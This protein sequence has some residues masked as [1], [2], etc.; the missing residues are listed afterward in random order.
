[1]VSFFIPSLNFVLLLFIILL[2]NSS[3]FDFEWK[4][5][6]VLF[7]KKGVLL[8]KNFG[9]LFLCSLLIWNSFSLLGIMI[10][11][12]SG[13]IYELEITLGQDSWEKHKKGQQQQSI[14]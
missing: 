14:W 1:M 7:L 4:I 8:L 12:E 6:F 2:F 9:F 10:L 11:G 13:D 3:V 5:L